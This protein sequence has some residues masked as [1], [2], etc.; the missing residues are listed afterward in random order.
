M[1]RGKKYEVKLT[2]EQEV[3]FEVLEYMLGRIKLFKEA[4]CDGQG[5]T[6]K[7]LQRLLKIRYDRAFYQ[8]TKREAKAKTEGVEAEEPET[9]LQVRKRAV[10]LM[11]IL[12]KAVEVEEVEF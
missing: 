3:A 9:N 2:K 11:L 1:P 8:K 5:L 6:E 7:Q 12:C 10:Q 4:I